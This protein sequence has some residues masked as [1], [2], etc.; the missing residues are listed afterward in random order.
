MSIYSARTIPE[1][2]FHS[3]FVLKWTFIIDCQMDFYFLL[4]HK[5]CGFIAK[6]ILFVGHLFTHKVE[7]HEAH[8][9]FF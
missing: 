7:V 6:W 3:L 9:F 2:G 8:Q 4:V 5:L 1:S